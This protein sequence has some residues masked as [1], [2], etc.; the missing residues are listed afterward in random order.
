MVHLSATR[1]S[2]IA[3]LWVNLVSFAAIA[4]CDASQKVFIIVVVQF[5]I[6]SVRKLLDTPSYANNKGTS[7]HANW[8]PRIRALNCAVASYGR[9]HGLKCW[10]PRPTALKQA[11]TSS[12]HI[13][14]NKNQSLQ[15]VTNQHWYLPNSM[16]QSVPWEANSRKASQEITRL[17][18][19][20]R[21]ITVF[22]T[23]RSWSLSS[24]R[25][26]QS[27]RSH[28]I[29]LTSIIILSSHLCVG[30]PSGPFRFSDKN[31]VCTS[32]CSLAC[33]IPRPSQF[34]HPNNIWWCVHR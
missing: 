28:P 24:A 7:L 31:I 21:F 34:D 17:Y 27:I 26:I 10:V 30:L 13:L 2:C 14:F 1:C 9:G 11:T 5:V 19:I 20:R 18:G 22:T 32:H 4:L 8:I 6:E 29:S 23:P 33:Y 15:R 12:F 25:W 16:E 3:I